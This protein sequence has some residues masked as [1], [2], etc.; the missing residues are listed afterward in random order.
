M[1]NNMKHA[2][3]VAGSIVAINSFAAT[4][5]DGL[6]LG[7]FGGYAYLPDNID[8]YRYDTHRSDA[9]YEAGYNA[10][11]AFG[12]KGN[13]LRYE[14]ELAYIRANIDHF[15]VNNVRDESGSGY[16]DA[17]FATANVYYDMCELIPAFVPWVGGGLGYAWVEAKL[18]NFY[19][20]P[21]MRF[22]DRETVL[23]FRGMAGITYNFAENYAL[24]F[25][26]R[27]GVTDKGH[28]GKRF[29]A[30]MANISAIYRFDGANYI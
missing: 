22:S 13:R 2:L 15:A 24:D 28:L 30:H 10:G 18:N 27:Y 23:A 29:Q 17:I 25:S 1:N 8:N 5:I 3:L 6:Y 12:Y 4:A 7:V 11:A 16:S 14:G 9:V 19:T 21:V 26:Y 20:E